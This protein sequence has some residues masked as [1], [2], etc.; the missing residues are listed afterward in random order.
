[1]HHLSLLDDKGIYDFPET[2]ETPDIDMTEE[3]VT[4]LQK[5]F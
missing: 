5:D 4:R 3:E 1:M 2:F